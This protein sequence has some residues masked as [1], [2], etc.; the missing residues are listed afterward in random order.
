MKKDRNSKRKR[1]KR[2]TGIHTHMHAFTE[3]KY[4]ACAKLA[5]RRRGLFSPSVEAALLLVA[6]LAV[7]IVGHVLRR[8]RRVVHLGCLAGFSSPPSS[9]GTVKQAADVHRP[10]L[11]LLLRFSSC[12]VHSNGCRGEAVFIHKRQQRGH[13]SS[14]PGASPWKSPWLHHSSHATKKKVHGRGGFGFV[15]TVFLQA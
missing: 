10:L 9:S 6:L 12:L 4:N 14:M 15:S 11:L 1:K 2:K 7:F 3:F 8:R 13:H 5:G